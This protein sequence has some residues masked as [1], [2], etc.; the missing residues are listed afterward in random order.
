MTAHVLIIEDNPANLELM[1]YVLDAFRYRVS[2]AADGESGLAA[3]AAERPDLVL[4]DVQLPGIDGYEVVRQ[5]RGNP[6]LAQL[7]VI[8]VTALAMDGY[9]SKPIDPADFVPQIEGF[10]APAL[11]TPAPRAASPTA[12]ANAALPVPTRTI[13]A[14]DNLRSNLELVQS[15]FESIGYRVITTVKVY[16][17]VQLARTFVPDVIISDVCMP[18]GS[19]FDLIRE[20]KADP[21]LRSIP[22]VFITS[23]AATENERR[24]GLRL[25]AA[26]YLFRPLEPQELIAAVESCL[27]TRVG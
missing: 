25:G 27:E 7:P 14:V 13:L 23:T 10:L 12:Q 9:V 6:L 4:C 17:V 15:I 8:A 1:R 3:M 20:I 24:A 5:M 26:K 21:A 11:R 18:T 16:E 19:G 2:T 22:F